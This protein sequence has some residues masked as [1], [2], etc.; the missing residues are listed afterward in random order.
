MKSACRLRRTVLLLSR[1]VWWLRGWRQR[2]EMGSL[3][4]TKDS[5][6]HS[7]PLLGG[8]GPQP[9]WESAGSSHRTQDP[10]QQP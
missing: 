5:G 1:L 8:I 9:G 6:Q 10:S 3:Q 2:S 4:G 7:G